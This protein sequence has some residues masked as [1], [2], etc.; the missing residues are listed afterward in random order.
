MVFRAL[1]DFKMVWGNILIFETTHQEL[2]CSEQHSFC[3]IELDHQE[4][5]KSKLRFGLLTF[6]MAVYIEFDPSIFFKIVYSL[7]RVYKILLHFLFLCVCVFSIGKWIA[8]VENLSFF[9]VIPFL[10]EVVKS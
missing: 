9:S 8:F 7:F 1:L 6:V 4:F 3:V 5:E 2:T 10:K